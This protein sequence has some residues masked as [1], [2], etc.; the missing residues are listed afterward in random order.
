[1]P[2]AAGLE[3]GWPKQ[4]CSWAG[5]QCGEGSLAGAISKLGPSRLDEDMQL[6]F[7]SFLRV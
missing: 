3:A 7:I 6:L 5:W 4:I 1:M 2:W